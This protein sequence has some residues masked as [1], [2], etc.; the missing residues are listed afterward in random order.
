M[1]DYRDV[2]MAVFEVSAKLFQDL[3]KLTYNKKHY[4]FYK[5]YVELQELI[6]AANR[7]LERLN[8]AFGQDHRLTFFKQF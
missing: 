5:T 7:E 1:N 6:R 8:L 3:F 2:Y 4:R